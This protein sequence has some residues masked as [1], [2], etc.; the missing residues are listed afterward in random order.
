[1]LDIR[2]GTSARMRAVMMK[3]G[4]EKSVKM[5]STKFPRQI[6]ST[7]TA[8]YLLSDPYVSFFFLSA[9]SGE[10]CGKIIQRFPKKDWE[11][12]AFPQ[13]VEMVSDKV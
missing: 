11:G 4:K 3:L 1:M 10:G 12:T 2:D 5:V 7:L 9:G 13:G 8:Y 6:S